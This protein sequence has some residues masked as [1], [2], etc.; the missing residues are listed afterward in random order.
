MGCE[1][2]LIRLSWLERGGKKFL[3]LYTCFLGGG[4]SHLVSWKGI[5][6]VCFS[7]KILDQS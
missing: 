4:C 1:L 7:N 6:F 3:M 5:K 2:A